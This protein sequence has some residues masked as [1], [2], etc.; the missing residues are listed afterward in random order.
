MNKYFYITTTLPYVNSK[1][2]VGFA[3]EVIRADAIARYK[4]LLG[5]NVFFNTG[6]DEHG[7][8][9][10]QKAQELGKDTKTFVDEQVVAFKSISEKMDISYDNFIRTTDPNHEKSAQQFWQVCDKNGA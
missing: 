4:R 3:M 6:T 1:P 5:Y 8:K 10:F 9:I 7:I 2:H